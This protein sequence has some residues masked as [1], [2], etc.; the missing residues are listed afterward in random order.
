MGPYSWHGTNSDGI[1][2]GN[3]FGFGLVGTT[4][5]MG[6]PNGLHGRADSFTGGG[7]FGLGSDGQI[8]GG[9][10][11]S[12]AHA[13]IGWGQAGQPGGGFY[14]GADV[15]AFGFDAHSWVNPDKGASAGASAY[16]L[17]GS[18]TLGNIGTGNHDEESRFGLGLGVGAAGRLHWD[19]ADGDGLREYGFG[20]DI[21]PISFDYKT[22]D[23]AR[24]LLNASTFGMG[25]MAADLFG[26]EGNM[27]QDIGNAASSAASWI[28]DTAS[29]IGSGISSG[30]GAAAS[31]VGGLIP[32]W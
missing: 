11:G 25:G 22:E 23:P 10:K 7:F 18:A 29:S 16:V 32:S 30:V 6:D 17:Q 19:D 12:A 24:S 8:G 21:G 27:T 13:D 20:A 5:P 15:D 9:I 28:G 26:Y 2:G 4:G 3:E 1:G 31:F 14:G